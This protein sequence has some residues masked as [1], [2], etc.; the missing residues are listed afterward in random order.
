MP[1]DADTPES[2]LQTVFGYDRFRP[3]QREII[4]DLL[5]GR[6]ALAIMPTGG[7]KSLCF[8]VPALLFDGL[9]VVVSPLLALMKDQVEQMVALGVPAVQLNSAL[10]ADTYRSHVGDV[11]RGRARLLYVAP[12]TLLMPRTLDLIEEAGPSCLAIDEAHC[13]SDWGH[14]FRPEYRQL[15]E[16]R[17][18]FPG[19]PC[20]ALT[21]TATPR[22]RDDIRAALDLGA[23]GEYVASFDRENLFLE[24]SPKAD[25]IGQILEFL[26]RYRGQPGIVYAFSRKQVDTLAAQIN[27]AGHAARPYHAGLDDA[28]RQGNQE[29]FVRDDT[30]V[31]VATVAFGMGINK[32]NVRFVIHHDLPKSLESYYQEVGR[33]GRDGLPAHC[34]LLYSNADVQK[35]RYFIDQKDP[36]ERKAALGHLDAMVRYA[37]HETGCRRA[38]LLSYF[39]ETYES[40]GCPMCDLCTDPARPEI[41]ITVLAQKFLSCVIRAGERFGGGHIADILLGSRSEK[42]IQYGHDQISTHGIGRDLDRKQWMHLGRQLVA[43]G[44][45]AAS[46]PPYHTLSVTPLGRSVLRNRDTILGRVPEVQPRKG[47]RAGRSAT[48]TTTTAGST[49]STPSSRPRGA[50]AVPPHDEALF[51][52]LRRRRKELADEAG[53]PP[54]VVFSDR[55]L[56]EMAAQLPRATADLLSIHGVGQ[57]KVERYG[58]AFLEVIAAHRRDHG[59]T[60]GD[61]SPDP[62]PRP[63]RETPA[64]AT[65]AAPGVKRFEEVGRAY[66]EGVSIDDLATRYGVRIDTIIDHLGTYS[67]SGQALRDPDGIVAASNL[68]EPTRAAVLTAFGELGTRRLRAV[69][70]RFSGAVPYAELKLLR[71]LHEAVFLD[72][73]R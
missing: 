49:T 62:G 43:R 58:D 72:P 28:T 68:D 64:P 34:L 21:A 57:V 65:A 31:I 20:L 36:D 51:D 14:D 44:L 29:A 73:A 1:A 71:L 24:V 67:A 16:V 35:I 25:G 45:L 26:D 40:D 11:R 7:G 3:H 6:D 33:A 47:R 4:G 69:H 52:R 38:P 30:A 27:A 59:A 37:E 54:Y 42:V 12:E 39:G 63:R 70:E 48:T 15:R 2:I 8:Q 60:D 50:G 55:T 66:N 46:E 56:I 32:P 19:T 41:D 9:T 53:V 17:E 13:I 5:D 10:D 61:R 23:C 18:R 22:V